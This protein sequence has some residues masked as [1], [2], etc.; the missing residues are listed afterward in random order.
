MATAEEE[1]ILV[2]FAF[3][4]VFLTNPIRRA[5]LRPTFDLLDYSVGARYFPVVVIYSRMRRF[6]QRI[7]WVEPKQNVHYDV[8][9]G[10][11]W[12]TTPEM[13]DRKY[14]RSYRMSYLAFE[15]L[16]SELTHFLRP[17]AD[18]F[19]RPPIPI[20]KHVSL[21]VYRLAQGLSCKAMDSLYG[22]GESTIRKYTLI[23]CKVLSSADGLFGR[24]IHAPT[25]HRLTDTIRKFREK[26]NLP[27]VVGAID[28]THI[29]LSSKPARGLTPMLCDFFNN[30][31]FHSV[32]LQ[33]V[34]DSEGFF[35]N[36]CAGEPGGV[37]DAA[38][39]AWLELY[40]Q[41]RRRDILSEPVLEIG[42]VEVRPY[43]LGDSVYLSRPYLL[44]FFKA[45]VTDLRFND[46]FFL[47]SL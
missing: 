25:G 46:K 5:R 12:H 23:V 40:A 42:A 16:V 17:T 3:M 29:P 9:E 33:V 4:V 6:P 2:F 14:C 38:Q 45:S 31:L 47:M 21:V 18:M 15:H 1:L 43:L 28:G 22:C 8:V 37:Y 44:K 32:L 13:L 41:L 20:R 7:W 30:F 35:W 10:D 19:V 34:C 11:V 36:I 26:T 39:F 24:Y 27:N